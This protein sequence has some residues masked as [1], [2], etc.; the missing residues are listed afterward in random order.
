MAIF[1]SN[2]SDLFSG[3]PSETAIRNYYSS[4]EYRISKQSFPRN[5]KLPGKMI[6]GICFVLEGSCVYTF[7]NFSVLLNAGQFCEL[8]G[9]QYE[10]EVLGER[11]FAS[12]LVW[13]LPPKFVKN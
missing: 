11:D 4:T 7:N 6:P 3:E 8:P 10:I 5:I 9:G 2:W 1:A 13:K 12:V